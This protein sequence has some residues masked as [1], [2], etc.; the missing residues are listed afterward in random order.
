[1][2][3]STGD[4]TVSVETSPGRQLD[5]A[6]WIRCLQVLCNHEVSRLRAAAEEFLLLLE[7]LNELAG[8]VQNHQETSPAGRTNAEFNLSDLEKA[9]WKL[10]STG[11]R[12]YSLAGEL[13]TLMEALKVAE[14][15]TLAIGG[16]TY[17]L[18]QGSDRAWRISRWPSNGGSSK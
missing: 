14:K 3:T 6:P 16:Y 5:F 18:W 7:A 13:P 1:M 8:P 12:S 10:D 9:S 17:E 15:Q 4:K 11:R 2:T